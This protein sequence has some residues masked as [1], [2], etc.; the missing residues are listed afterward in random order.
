MLK[1]VVIAAVLIVAIAPSAAAQEPPPIQDLRGAMKA[2]F[3]TPV[4]MAP[5]RVFV[6]SIG[7][8]NGFTDPNK[9]NQDSVKD[10]QYALRDHHD[11]LTL[12]DT[13][14]AATI[15]LVVTSREKAQV[16]AGFFGASRDC[17]VRLKFF[18]RESETE[19]SASAAGGT[20]ASGGAWYAAAD[21]LVQQVE[22]WVKANRAQLSR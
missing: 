5:V 15:V 16:T 8:V 9:G 7:A 20:L 12:T 11:L 14:E 19:M 4:A 17:T 13:R 21:K 6:T 18:F 1:S 2:A 3:A 22:H 10:L